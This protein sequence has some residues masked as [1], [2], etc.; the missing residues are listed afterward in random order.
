MGGFVLVISKTK[1]L[2]GLADLFL[3]LTDS[4]LEFKAVLFL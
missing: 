1:R 4:F 3:G 2:L